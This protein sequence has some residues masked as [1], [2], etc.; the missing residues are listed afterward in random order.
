MIQKDTVTVR[1]KVGLFSI[2]L[3]EY[4]NQFTG[5]RPRL[6]TYNQTIQSQIES[7]G[8]EV[9]NLGLVDTPER[10]VAAGH[11]F[12]QA[13]VDLIF[14]HVATYALSATVLPVVRRPGVPVIVLNLSPQASIDY[15]S[16]NRMKDRTAMT[17]EW[18]AHCQACS[19]PEIS[20]VFHRSGIHFH[21]VVGMLHGDPHVWSEISEWIEAS[22]VAFA[23][24][25]NRLGIMGHYYSGMLDIYSDLSLQ[26]STFGT[27]IEIIEVDELS[28]LRRKVTP[29]QVKAR[30][31]E[32]HST[33]DI[34]PD[35]PTEEL[36]R[37]AN[38]SVALDL[39]VQQHQLGSLAYYYKG[40]GIADNEGTISSIIPGCCLLTAR[41]IPVAGELEVKNVQA[42]KILDLLGAGGSFTEFYANDFND[43]VIL[44]GHDGP[45][46]VAIAQGKP[47]LRSLRVYHGKVGLGL[48]VEMS[49]KHGPVTLLS[50][51]EAGQGAL[52]FVVAE[53]ESVPGPILEIGNTNSR[54]RFPIGAREFLQAWSA[55][56]TAHHCA[57]G[58][59]HKSSVLKKLAKLCGVEIIQIS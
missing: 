20:N 46:H 16:F 55:Q 25:H 10:A 17:G 7:L 4:W 45:G 54:Y 2:G 52:K 22:R 9:V 57:I 31:A 40:S 12:R 43:D 56:G 27:Q 41:G 37:A 30:V 36:E 47:R 32:L 11:A 34:E 6:E 15:D 14:L 49:V 35:A 18:L 42:M 8:A 24:E 48:S 33:F 5:L 39:L 29:A 23:M 59:G 3:A 1:H 38:T 21:Q 50:V 58:V 51:S 53:G 44:M 28:S 13:D 19:V 26:S